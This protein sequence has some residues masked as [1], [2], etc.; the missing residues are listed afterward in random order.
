MKLPSHG[1]NPQFLYNSLK[2]PMPEK[3]IDFSV[4]LNPLG[5]PKPLTDILSGGTIGFSDYPDPQHTELRSRLSKAEGIDPSGI[6]V[7]NGAAEIIHMIGCLLR[8]KHVAI[9]HPAF[10]E[11]EQA[12]L[13]FSCSL[14][15]IMPSSLP[16][17]EDFSRALEK[18]DALFICNPNNPTGTVMDSGLLERII[19]YGEANGCLVIVDEAFHDFLAA[20]ESCKEL[21]GKHSN[22]IILRS[23]TKMFSMAGIRLGYALMAEGL[24]S[25]L[26]K[27]QPPWSVNSIA[28]EAGRVCLDQ[29][30]F[31]LKTRKYVIKEREKMFSFFRDN[32]FSFTDSSTNFY[33]FKDNRL[34]NQL[35]LITF[36]L[37][38]RIVPRHTYNFRGLEGKWMRMAVKDEEANKVLME[39]LRQWRQK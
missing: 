17:F 8:G 10:S 12:C 1:S 9:L 18:A 2:V 15:H 14:I 38:N 22:L 16:V 37:T 5:P 25:R 23:M 21:L 39:V 31:V 7:G 11:Y 34:G 28:L 30:E 29:R 24:R 6:L 27:Y 36:L 26:V 4:N 19:A 3:L 35:D 13:T 32:D 33:L 20:G